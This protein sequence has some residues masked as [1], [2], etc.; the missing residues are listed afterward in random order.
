MR[1]PSEA[2]TELDTVYPVQIDIH[3]DATGFVPDSHPNAAE[4]NKENHAF[5]PRTRYQSSSS[6]FRLSPPRN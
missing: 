6:P 2:A 4:D 1:T 5:F 3:V